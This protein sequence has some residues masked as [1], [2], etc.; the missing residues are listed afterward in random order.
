MVFDQKLQD[1]LTVQA[2]AIPLQPQAYDWRYSANDG[3]QRM[4]NAL[5]PGPI[6]L[7]N[8]HRHTSEAMVMVRGKIIERLCKYNG[9]PTEEY[10]MEPFGQH[11][12]AKIEVAQ[13]HSLEELEEDT[14]IFEAIKS[15]YKP[16]NADDVLHLNEK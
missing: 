5:E 12:M 14:A 6:M 7:T 1:E 16:L 3:S 15:A 4:L 10:V 9:N 2:K 8:R 13:W 11:S